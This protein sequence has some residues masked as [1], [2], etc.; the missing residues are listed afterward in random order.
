MFILKKI[1][2]AQDRKYL[3][4]MANNRKKAIDLIGKYWW[5]IVSHFFKCIIF[6]KDSSYNHWL[7]EIAAWLD[8]VNHQLV[9]TKSLKF[10]KDVY[11]E[12]TFGIT[13]SFDL[14]DMK[15]WLENFKLGDG[16]K[17]PK[18]DL[19]RGLIAKCFEYYYMLADY[20]S[21]LFEVDKSD[22]NKT[23]QFKNVIPKILTATKEGDIPDWRTLL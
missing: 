8:Y 20:F 16:K 3:L 18:F 19:S 10:K 12:E 15:G 23:S 22:K 2:E 14:R 9:K 6:P 21:S 17:Y 4:E 5:N 11:M 13:D 7:N 1:V